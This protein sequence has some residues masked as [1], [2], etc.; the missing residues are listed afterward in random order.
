MDMQIFL[1]GLNILGLVVALFLVII[2]IVYV[3]QW[4]KA[5]IERRDLIV[6]HKLRKLR[7]QQEL[8]YNIF[9]EELHNPKKQLPAIRGEAINPPVVDRCFEDDLEECS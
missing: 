3:V 6:D 5:S 8:D 2:S 7:A 1:L 4:V 9:Y